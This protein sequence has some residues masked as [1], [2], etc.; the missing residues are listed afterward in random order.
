[1]PFSHMR[2]RI[3]LTVASMQLSAKAAMELGGNDDCTPRQ[4]RIERLG[5]MTIPPVQRL[6]GVDEGHLLGLQLVALRVQRLQL[7]PT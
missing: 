7:R 6:D 4:A 1:M 2:V 3:A 5:P